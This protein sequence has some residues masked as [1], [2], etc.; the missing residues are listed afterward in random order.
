MVHRKPFACPSCS[1]LAS[2]VCVYKKPFI[3]II[4][5]TLP[6][7]QEANFRNVL[8]SALFRSHRQPQRHSPPVKGQRNNTRAARTANLAFDTMDHHRTNPSPSPSLSLPQI[9]T[10]PL[11][12]SRK[13]HRQ[14]QKRTERSTAT[15]I[16][17]Y[18]FTVILMAK[19]EASL[20]LFS[21]RV[22]VMSGALRWN[23]CCK[24]SLLPRLSGLALCIAREESRRFGLS[25]LR[26]N[27]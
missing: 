2:I 26:E 24:T 18:H 10:R 16:E 25:E 22:S 11:Q 9:R 20:D 4:S 3:T 7:H 12:S 6:F 8:R 21:C 17:N 5:S 13:T 19:L 14:G 27:G 15:P 1:V 23:A